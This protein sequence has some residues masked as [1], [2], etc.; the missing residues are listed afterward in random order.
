MDCGSAYRWRIGMTALA[1]EHWIDP[2]DKAVRFGGEEL[3]SSRMTK[4]RARRYWLVKPGKRS[5][6]KETM[7]SEYEKLSIFLRNPWEP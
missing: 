3:G 7:V 1:S 5:V 4:V 2:E 6:W